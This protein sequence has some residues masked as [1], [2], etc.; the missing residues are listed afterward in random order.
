[1]TDKE[2]KTMEKRI[3]IG[4]R[5]GLPIVREMI[6]AT[7]MTIEYRDDC[8]WL[9]KK[10]RLSKVKP[11]QIERLNAAIWRIGERLAGVFIHYSDDRQAVIDQ[12]KEHLHPVKL[13]Y[14]YER[15]L[16]HD[17]AW[18]TYRTRSL[19]GKGYGYSFT[20]QEVFHIN[21][22]VKEISA[23]L[24]SIELVPDDLDETEE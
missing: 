8:Q 2:Y 9:T 1:M 3:K 20:E 5:M 6:T 16:G 24:L 23:R 18:W 13:R 7:A 19:R 11:Y 10:D 4:V 17:T 14:I 21:L 12:I 15:H 22:A